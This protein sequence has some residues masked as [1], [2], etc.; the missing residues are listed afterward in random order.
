MICSS[1]KTFLFGLGISAGTIGEFNGYTGASTHNTFIQCFYHTG[2]IGSVLFVCFLCS[3]IGWKKVFKLKAWNALII[4]AVAMF[5]FGLDF[6][7][8][9]FSNYFILIMLSYPL[10]NKKDKKNKEVKVENTSDCNPNVQQG[11]LNN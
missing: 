6:F 7:S 11:E 10:G 8:Y 9:R 3:Y 2:L 5:L 4:M 1:V